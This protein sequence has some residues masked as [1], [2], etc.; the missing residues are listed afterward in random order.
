MVSTG[1]TPVT[2]QVFRLHLLANAPN[3]YLWLMM[4]VT[5]CCLIV[6]VPRRTVARKEVETKRANELDEKTFRG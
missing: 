2:G 5:A 4:Q 6:K 3:Y 1:D